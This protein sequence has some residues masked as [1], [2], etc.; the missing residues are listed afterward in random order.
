MKTPTH[1]SIRVSLEMGMI[2]FFILAALSWEMARSNCSVS[3][4]MC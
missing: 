3:G 1:S 4:I 2:A